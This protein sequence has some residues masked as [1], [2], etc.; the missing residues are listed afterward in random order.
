MKY[1]DHREYIL[2][3]H[4]QTDYN[5][6]EKFQ[7]S[8]DIVLNKTGRKQ[9]RKIRKL[10][11]QENINIIYSSDLVR[12]IQTAEY[13]SPGVQVLVN[14]NFRE[15][16]FGVFEGLTYGEIK[17]HHGDEYK[18]WKENMMD[19]VID[20]GESFRQMSSRV[21]GEFEKIRANHDRAT[22]VSHAGC[23]RTILSHYI[24]GNIEDSWRF[25]IEN[26]SITKLCFNRDYA[27]L[28]LL[29]LR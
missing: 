2:I 27:Y 16:N 1:E 9:A 17:E 3:R 19:H 4:G 5:L 21:I 25:F 12:C 28:K 15:M 14:E 13:V 8:S 6:Q 23:I 10:Y 24:T 22:L 20:G 29:N 26:C 7:G 18:K 11:K